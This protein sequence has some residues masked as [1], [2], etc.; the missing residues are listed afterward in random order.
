MDSLINLILK[1]FTSSIDP[2]LGV[3]DVKCWVSMNNSVAASI[4]CY[5]RV[6]TKL[7]V[8]HTVT[9]V[10]CAAIDTNE[11][12]IWLV[13]SP[14]GIR[15]YGVWSTRRRTPSWLHVVSWT[16]PVA[17]GYDVIIL[18]ARLCLLT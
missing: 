1:Q 15:L 10:F 13:H 16:G 14:I 17:I 4:R 3:T 5:Q 8:L 11:I 2:R 18:G 12:R 9:R 6:P 7:S